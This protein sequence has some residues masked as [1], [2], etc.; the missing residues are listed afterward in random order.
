ME[1]HSEIDI[2]KKLCDYSVKIFNT[3]ETNFQWT[4]SKEHD[5]LLNDIKYNPHAFVI[6]CLMNRQ[7]KAEKVGLIPYELKRRI[8]DF[9]FKTLLEFKKKEL[10]TF[11]NKPTPLHRYTNKMSEYLY[12]AIQKIKEK[13]NGDA[14]KIWSNRPSSADVVLRFLEFDGIGQKIATMAANLLA[15]ELKVKFCDYYSID[16][17]V[18]V[19][20]R[21]VFYRLGLTKKKSTT[22]QVIYKARAM[23]PEFPG[24]LDFACY[25]IGK[26]WCRPKEKKCD[27]CFMNN[28][29][30]SKV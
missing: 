15:R 3:S 4:G 14:S 21:R 13:Y 10:H 20:V 24:M 16:I 18:D 19:H 22:E 11:L 26:N 30:P 23:N 1:K 12:K 6:A 2:K 28:V 7:I 9:S 8:G 17:S 5:K 29:C 27:K 25:T